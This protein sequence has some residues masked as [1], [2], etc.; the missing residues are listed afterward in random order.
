MGGLKP[1]AVELFPVT[2]SLEKDKTCDNPWRSLSSVCV[3][4]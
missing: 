2:A 1:V 4:A 3:A